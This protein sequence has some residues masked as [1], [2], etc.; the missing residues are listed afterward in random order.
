[1]K[2]A[3]RVRLAATLLSPLLLFVIL[4]IPYAWLNGHFIVD[5]LGCGC[6][7]VDEFGNDVRPALS[8]NGFTALFF[9]FV[10]VCVTVIAVF[11][12]Q[13]IPRRKMW[14]RILYVAG[15]LLASLLMTAHFYRILMWC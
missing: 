5:W 14:L 9:L 3:T 13:R 4:F 10:S 11:L 6:P 2:T 7:R 1:M 12:S 15:M 8:A